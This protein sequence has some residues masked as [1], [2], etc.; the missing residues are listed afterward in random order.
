VAGTGSL[1]LERYL[2][3]VEGHGSP[4]GNFLLDLKEA[5]P[6]SV[7][8][9]ASVS[10]PRWPSEA[11]RVV[12]LQRRVQAISMAFLRPVLLD[13]KPFV[14]RALQPTEDRVDLSSLS[15]EAGRLEGLMTTLGQLVAWAQ[16]RSSGRQGSATADGLIDYWAKPRRSRKLY[17]LARECEEQLA[18]DWQ[19][20]RQGYEAGALTRNRER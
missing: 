7:A 11:H 13:G 3:C 17:E 6:S 1:G 4:D 9:H 2:L 14:L 20:Y 19:E 5:M 15:G 8:R 10:Q 12:A 18:S 16:L